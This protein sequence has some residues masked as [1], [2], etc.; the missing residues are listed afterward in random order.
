MTRENPHGV[1]TLDDIVDE[2][3]AAKEQGDLADGARKHDAA[4]AEAHHRRRERSHYRRAARIAF[5]IREAL[6]SDV[7][8]RASEEAIRSSA[9]EAPEAVDQPSGAQIIVFPRNGG[10][11]S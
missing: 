5:H 7:F 4:D 2:N 11:E 1:W 10:L 8:A 6:V 3:L 9:I